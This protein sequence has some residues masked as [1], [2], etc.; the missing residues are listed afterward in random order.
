M[1]INFDEWNER[2]NTNCGKW[3]TMD[4][5]YQKEGMLHLGVADMDF[6]SP[7]Q[8]IDAFQDILDKGIFGYTDLSDR[9][10]E[11]IREWMRQKH[12]AEVSR[13][14]I[15]FCPRINVS[16]S[17]CV[18]TF[19]EEMDEV[20]INTPAYGP[21]YQA[22]VKNHRKVVESPLILENGSYKI[23]FA[24]LES[25]VTDKTKMFI[26]CSPHN[27]VGRVWT[28]EELEEV[29]AFCKKHD[30]LL[31]VDEIHGDIVA[32]GV[33]FTTALT[34]SET[35]RERLIVATSLTKTFNVPG[36]IVSYMIVPNEEIRSRIAQT[37]DRIGMHN[38]T[39]FA[40][41]AVEHGYM[42]CE[43]WYQQMLD[44][45]NE[46][47]K[48]TREFFAE[49]FPEFEILERQGTY[50]LWI[51]YEKLGITEE[52]L[53]KWFLEKANV[54]VYM[55]SVFGNQG[56]GFIRLNIASPR[57]MLKEA[58]ERMAAVYSEL[59]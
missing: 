56:R 12:Q 46:N 47:E 23:D 45:V 25:V 31:F 2:R 55:G 49:H 27:P 35:V 14:E 50:L 18:E 42:E 40:V 54:S 30:L 32:E 44:Y 24:H 4:K 41:A 58:Y 39:I 1:K 9:F 43:E 20:I 29:G 37:I 19:T 6:R 10:Y 53:E 8:I 7:K 26:L 21:L 52:E 15:V 28:R 17:I 5:K 36:V 13:E 51:S 34:L 11:N 57:T 38:P 59:K 16:S 3:D 22:V 48:F 33:T